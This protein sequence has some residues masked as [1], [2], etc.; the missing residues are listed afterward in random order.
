MLV[1]YFK[2]H[3]FYG[4][5]SQIRKPYL[6]FKNMRDKWDYYTRRTNDSCLSILI[7]FASYI[8]NFIFFK[9]TNRFIDEDKT[10]NYIIETSIMEAGTL[11][12]NSDNE[13]KQLI[14][15]IELNKKY[16]EILN[17][18]SLKIYISKYK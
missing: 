8:L 2:N 13:G 18:D 15:N 1:E 6:V 9:D 10:Q 7:Y 4:I 17:L 3:N 12:T 11:Q 14:S 16:Q 5:E